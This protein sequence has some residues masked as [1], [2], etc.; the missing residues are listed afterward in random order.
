MRHQA[1]TKR[2][3]VRRLQRKSRNVHKWLVSLNLSRNKLSNDISLFWYLS[4]HVATTP[5]EPTAGCPFKGV[6]PVLKGVWKGYTQSCESYNHLFESSFHALSEST[7]KIC[8]FELQQ[9]EKSIKVRLPSYRN[10]G[11][12]R[13]VTRREKL[14]TNSES[15]AKISL[16]TLSIIFLHAPHERR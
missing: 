3:R 4:L 14:S 8:F 5:C 10:R 16:E 9:V 12:D 1:Y 15:S 13:L 7:E 6:G 11:T 2:L